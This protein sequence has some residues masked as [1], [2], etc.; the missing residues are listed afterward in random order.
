MEGA[1]SVVTRV[2]DWLWLLAIMALGAVLRIYRIDAPLWYDEVQTLVDFARLPFAEIA[3]RF[4]SFNNHVF[5]SLQA[6]LS[7]MLFGENVPALRAPA[8]IFGVAAIPVLWAL[9]RQIGLPM[10]WAHAATLLMAVNYHMIWFSQNARGYSGI[11][12]WGLLALLLLLRLR[13]G[14]GGLVFAGFVIAASLS[15][16]TH[17]SA[18][19]FIAALAVVFG[20]GALRHG[21]FARMFWAFAGVGAVTL[22]LYAP[23]LGQIISMFSPDTIGAPSQHATVLDRSAA[24]YVFWALASAL[25]IGGLP[26]IG[27]MALGIA[28]LGLGAA[29]ISRRCPGILPV[30]LVHLALTALVLLFAK[31]LIYP[32]YF[33]IEVVFLLVFA[34]VGSFRLAAMIE[35]ILPRIAPRGAIAAL[36][37]L[38]GV[39]LSLLWAMRNYDAPKQ[40]IAGAVALVEARKSPGDV[41]LS[42]GLVAAPISR[43]YAPEWP[44][45]T[46]REELE[47]FVQEH[48]G[49]IWIVHGF[50][51]HTTRHYGPILDRLNADFETAARFPGTLADG[52]VIV[53]KYRK[54]P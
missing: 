52:A 54:T 31:M 30:L 23:V 13:Q 18:G 14:G 7:L 19:F 29:E 51:R 39:A 48:T 24:S 44:E 34:A 41:T 26:A 20:F 12:F 28:I 1:V 17:L 21:G 47:T 8:V 5:F 43:L 2:R 53:S 50:P 40:D 11:V 16:Y 45:L 6:H 33:L 36:G 15:I 49:T 10:I 46:S 25:P 37:I 27:A 38:C 22:C 32:R 35:R 42:L 9:L 3:T 4:T